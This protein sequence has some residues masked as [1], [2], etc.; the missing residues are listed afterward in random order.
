M[1]LIGGLYLV[2][3]PISL[4]VVW[5]LL[6]T[7][8]APV[9]GISLI[10][11]VCIAL[12]L[13]SELRSRWQSDKLV[14]IAE[15]HEPWKAGLFQALL[16]KENVSCVIRGYYHRSL[17]YLFGPYIEMTVY[18]AADNEDVAREVARKYMSLGNPMGAA[19]TLSMDR[20]KENL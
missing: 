1:A 12:D 19:A 15:F 9:N 17:L 6:Q 16:Q 4:Q 8:V 11:A 20:P 10:V 14:R 7:T 13:S 3:L 5:W 2:L 18:A